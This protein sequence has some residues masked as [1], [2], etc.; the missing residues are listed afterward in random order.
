MHALVRAPFQRG[1]V[2]QLRQ[3]ALLRL[4]EEVNPGDPLLGAGDD[5]LQQRAEV[6]HHSGD[7]CRL[8]EVG[9]VQP[10]GLQAPVAFHHHGER[11]VHRR[12]PLA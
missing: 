1:S 12:T 9:V 11:Q 6:L 3:P 4:G 7:G 10:R 5:R 8:E 2:G